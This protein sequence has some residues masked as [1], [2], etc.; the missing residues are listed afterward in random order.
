MILIKPIICAICLFLI[1]GCGLTRIKTEVT[2]PYTDKTWVI[3]SKNDALV[4]LETK[5][6]TKIEVDNRGS[7][8][9]WELLILRS[10][11]E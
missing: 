5:D 1:A 8:G 2:N 9:L 11:P 4:K 6:G 3:L 7:V 10:M